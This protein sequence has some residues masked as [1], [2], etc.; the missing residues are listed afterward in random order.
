MSCCPD[1][2][3]V[4]FRLMRKCPALG[5]LCRRRRS[6]KGGRCRSST[7]I[8]RRRPL[9]MDSR[10]SRAITRIWKPAAFLFLI[11]G[12]DSAEKSLVEFFGIAV[13]TLLEYTRSRVAPQATLFLY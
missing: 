10:S 4:F 13:G 6:G 9:F 11:P 2:R 12:N 7:G 5:D 3:G 8:L 1:F